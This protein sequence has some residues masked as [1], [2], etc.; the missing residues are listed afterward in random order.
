MVHRRGLRAELAAILDVDVYSL[1]DLS[2]ES[3][4]PNERTCTHLANLI[5]RSV[6]HSEEARTIYEFLPTL[7]YRIFGYAP[8]QGWLETA[9][10]LPSRDREALVRLIIPDGP[11]H[12][13]CIKYSPSRDSK[14]NIATDMRFEFPRN[15]IPPLTNEALEHGSAGALRKSIK[16]GQSFLAPFLESAIRDKKD[17][18]LYLV[19][20]DYFYIC[21]IASPAQKWTRTPGSG[22]MGT[23]RV[24]RS[25][26]LPSTRAL[27]NQVVA[28]Y[29][30]SLKAGDNVDNDDIFI[31]TCLDYLFVPWSSCIP[32]HLPVISTCAAETVASI[33]LALAPRAPDALDFDVEFVSGIPEFVDWRWQTN[34]S[35]LFRA[36][37]SM[38]E[39]VLLNLDSSSSPGVL[40]VYMRILSLYIAPWRKCIRSTLKAQLFPKPKPASSYAAGL[41]PTMASL[42]KRLSSIN[43]QIASHATSPGNASDA[44]ESQWRSALKTR[45]KFVDEE[46]VRLT[47]VKAAN[48][49]IPSHIEGGK[50]LV[51][52]A[53]ATKAAGMAGSWGSPGKDPDMADEVRNC[54]EALRNQKVEAERHSGRK[55]KDYV[56]PLAA[57][58][59]VRLENGGVLSGISEMVGGGSGLGS[60]VSPASSGSKMRERR[61]RALH[62]VVSDATDAP[63]IGNVWDRPITESES[64]AVV[65]FLYWVA[66]RLE[67]HLGFVL[68]I[69]F[70][71]RHW[72]LFGSSVG[73]L[74]AFVAA[75]MSQMAG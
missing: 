43:A 5:Y 49:R 27:Y 72:V 45:Q 6:T 16:D 44:R 63:F 26:S 8:G 15:S 1:Q 50:C 33:L 32:P 68:N 28:S 58:L 22:S 10:E 37:E 19:P 38:L 20:L 54:L 65:L 39:S 56:A 42:T 69:R 35:V 34:S 23:R 59:G 55:D 25:I 13:F 17:D 64:E 60:I 57:S 46:L 71:G 73:L 29:A 7:M 21:M 70:L 52:L 47:V 36:A 51:L 67:P 11:V 9:S 66:L 74:L 40:I 14:L 61:L 62:A 2:S 53:E 24:K 12:A 31:A 41:T 30:S 75:K 3:S 4:S 48:R 18:C